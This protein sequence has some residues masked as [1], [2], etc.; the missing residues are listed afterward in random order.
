MLENYGEFHQI[1]I[2]DECGIHGSILAS[3]NDCYK[4]VKGLGENLH[5]SGNMMQH[6]FQYQ[7]SKDTLVAYMTNSPGELTGKF[8]NQ[9]SIN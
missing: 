7:F 4:R 3:L 1:H 6:V 2:I 8:S 5:L 9:V